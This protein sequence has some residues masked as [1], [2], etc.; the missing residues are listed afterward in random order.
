[1]KAYLSD[2]GAMRSYCEHGSTDEHGTTFET[3]AVD[4]ARRILADVEPRGTEH[5]NVRLLDPRGTVALSVRESL[6]AF[7]AE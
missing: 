7:V 5:V 3:L 6:A 1:M 4:E 2:A